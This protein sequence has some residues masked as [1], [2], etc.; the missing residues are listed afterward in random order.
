[1]FSGD[2][3]LLQTLGLSLVQGSDF[4]QDRTGKL[5]NEKLIRQFTITDPIGKTIPGTEDKIIGV[6][7]DFRCVS[8]KEEIP[9]VIISYVP[10]A[11]NILIDY[12]GQ[13][14]P[15]VLTRTAR[16]WRSVFPNHSFKYALIQEDLLKKHKEDIFFYKIITSFSIAS[17]VISCFG[18]F[19]LSWG[20]VQHKT[21]EIGIRKVLGASV[22]GIVA[23]LSRDFIRLV[24]IA[25][26]VAVPI[27]WYAMHQWLENFA[28][29]INLGAE[30][31]MLAGF[32]ALLIAILTISFQSIK[33][34][35]MN[36]VESLRNE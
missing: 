21:K 20:T 3:S 28:Y 29:R 12:T 4:L 14:L 27:A 2:E 26:V 24:L 23:L 11:E 19:A 18:L 16:S 13:N 8:L 17:I 33:A 5:V 7:K 34:A 31:F 32:T 30:V 15:L 10:D 9:P 35:L 22:P 6:V 25:F 36:P 1:L